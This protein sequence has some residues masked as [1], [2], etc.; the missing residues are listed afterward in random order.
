[1]YRYR[2]CCT[3]RPFRTNAGFPPPFKFGKLYGVKSTQIIGGGLKSLH[4]KRNSP[5]RL[6]KE[7]S[8]VAD[9]TVRTTSDAVQISAA[10]TSGSKPKGQSFVAK[11][12]L[13]GMT[14]TA[15]AGCFGGGPAPAAVSQQLTEPAVMEQVQPANPFEL[16]RLKDGSIAF[17]AELGQSEGHVDAS[18]A[19]VSADKSEIAVRTDE[20]QSLCEQATALGGTCLEDGSV[21]LNSPSGPIMIETLAR[22]GEAPHRIESRP[23][24]GSFM[25]G[26]SL[27][28]LPGGTEVF[29][30]NGSGLL[31]HDGQLNPYPNIQLGN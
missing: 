24:D 27:N 17:D 9:S 5:P 8:S 30:N 16:M 22:D 25:E 10:S 29:S 31:G 19:R 3:S 6:G 26:V 15:L 12:L 2:G 7:T 13:I 21:Q 28:K 1:M 14:A 20:N 18:S 4:L 11:A 23:V